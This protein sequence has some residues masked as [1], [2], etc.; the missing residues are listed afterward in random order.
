MGEWKRNEY[1]TSI[2]LGEYLKPCPRRIDSV[3]EE[4]GVVLFVRLQLIV[5]IALCF[6]FQF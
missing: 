2:C 3:E 4:N 1:K 6:Q 5:F